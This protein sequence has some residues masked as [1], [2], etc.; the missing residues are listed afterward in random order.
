MSSS[1]SS[2]ITTHV[3]EID[4]P[5]NVNVIVGQTHFIKTVDDIHEAMVGTVPNIK[6]GLAFCEASGERLIRVT[7]TDDEL[8]NVATKNAQQIACGHAF[9]LILGPPVFPIHIMNSLKS[10]PEVCRI[11]CATQNRLQLVVAQNSDGDGRGIMGVIDGQTP[12]GV[13][14]QTNI[15]E[16]R[17]FLKTIGYKL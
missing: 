2:S 14:D 9:I 8:V 13:E 7:G 4:K 3:V 6:F 17:Q 5:D 1:S 15:D 11:F 12:L 10:V 16:R